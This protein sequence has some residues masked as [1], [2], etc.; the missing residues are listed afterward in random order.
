MD[1]DNKIVMAVPIALMIF[2]AGVLL[3]SYLSTGEFIS[4]SFELRGGTLVSVQTAGQTDIGLLQRELTANF[5]DVSVREI[6]G[7]G[8][9][10]LQVGVDEKIDGKDVVAKMKEIGLTIVGSSVQTIGSSVGQTFFSQAQSAL[11]FAFFL[12]AAVVFFL[13]RK[14]LPSLYAVLSAFADMFVTMGFMQFLGIELSLASLGALLMLLGYSVDT[15]V[16]L[17]SRVMKQR[18]NEELKQKVRGA[19]KTGLTMTGTAIVA[20]SSIIITSISPVL[21]SIASVL[22][23]GLVADIVMTWLFNAPLLNWYMKRGGK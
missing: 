2:S 19:F 12:L 14:I 6:K 18:N 9:S 23:I 21:V 10:S 5:G 3:H 17:T 7:I 20:L 1:F 16:M 4:R 13:F 11:V 15:D 22:L 8:G